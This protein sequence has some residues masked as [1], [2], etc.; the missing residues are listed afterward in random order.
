MVLCGCGHQEK[1]N[2]KVTHSARIHL[3]NPGVVDFEAPATKCSECGDL[4]FHENDAEAVFN[5]FEKEYEKR[6]YRL[7]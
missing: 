5:N 6:T 2:A 1:K 3:S 4:I 7:E